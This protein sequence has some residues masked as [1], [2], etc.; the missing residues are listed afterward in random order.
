MDGR[1]RRC[2]EKGN[3]IQKWSLGSVTYVFPGGKIMSIF[4]RKSLPTVF[5]GICFLSF[6]GCN[7][8]PVSP[9]N[10]NNQSSMAP[11]TLAVP[12]G[13]ARPIVFKHI[14]AGTF[15]M[16]SDSL[17]DRGASPPHQVTLSAF[18]MSETHV[19]QEQYLAVMDTNPS[20]ADTGTGASLRPVESVSWFDAVKFCNALSLLSGLTVVYDT[21]AWTADFT[22]SGYRLPTEAQW[23]YACRAGSTTEWWWGS[24]TNGMGARTWSAYN[25]DNITHSVA[26][27]LA[28]VYG[29]YDMT[30][31]VWQWCS[32][33]YGDYTAG[34]ATDPTGPATGLCRVLRGAS[35]GYDISGV[36][37][38]DVFRSAYRYKYI[39]PTYKYD[40]YGFRVVLPR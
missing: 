30:G 17:E 8:N 3:I 18:K 14:P 38:E 21:S 20:Y 15:T 24:D 23:E 34:A 2:E 6:W 22:K 26:T 36:K 11:E 16:G 19:T 7:K 40:N 37:V 12:H 28:N 13:L 9:T 27:K 25:S 10:Q 32:D 31:N 5:I 33:Y 35:F 1:S 39:Y 29:L 4:L